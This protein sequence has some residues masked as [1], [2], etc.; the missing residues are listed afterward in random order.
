MKPGKRTRAHKKACADYR[1][2]FIEEHGFGYCESC[3]VNEM[4]FPPHSVHHIVYASRAVKNINN[5]VTDIDTSKK[6][7]TLKNILESILYV[8]LFISAVSYMSAVNDAILD[9]RLRAEQSGNSAVK[10]TER[11]LLM[12]NGTCEAWECHR[13]DNYN[14]GGKR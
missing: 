7:K 8:F 2:L 1:K 9:L 5:R 3:S 10:N 6:G 12:A 11:L 14:G 13:K 4:S